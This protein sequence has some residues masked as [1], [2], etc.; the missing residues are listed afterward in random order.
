MSFKTESLRFEGDRATTSEWV[1]DQWGRPA[2]RR[3]NLSAN[4]GDKFVV[5]D[6]LPSHESF[7]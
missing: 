6:V 7:Q 5:V 1:E 4:F 2:C 3:H